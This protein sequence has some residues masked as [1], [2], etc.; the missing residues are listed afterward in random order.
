MV[1][2]WD[3][4]GRV[5]ILCAGVV[6]AASGSVAGGSVASGSVAGGSAPDA[7]TA[8]S[9]R[10]GLSPRLAEA[11]AGLS[12]EAVPT[13][14]LA[15]RVV[16]LVDFAG[17][18]GAPGE[19]P[20]TLAE[21]RQLYTQV[22]RSAHGERTLPAL[23]E[24][25]LRAAP[26]LDRGVVPVAVLDLPY[27]RIR[28]D[29]LETGALAIRAGRLA[30]GSGSPFETRR[31]FAATALRDRTYQ[32]EA[33]T[34][35][36]GRADYI[37]S[38]SRP[39]RDVAIDFADG[40][41]FVR[42]SWDHERTVR[43]HAP[44]IKTVRIRIGDSGGAPREAAFLFDVRRLRTP[45]PDD[46]L[47]IQATL[48]YLG[49]PGTG[50]AYVYLADEH[51]ALTNPVLVIEGFDLDN[52]MGWDELYELLNREEL[53]ETLRVRGFD[54]VVLDFTDAVDYIQRNAFVAVELISQ[55]RAAIEP[56]RTIAL[57]GASMGGLIGRFALAY[58]EA[59]GIEHGA[60]TFISFDAPQDGANVPLGLQYWLWFFAS[61]SPEAAALLAALDAPGARQMLCYHHTDPPGAT[62]QSDPLRAQLLGDLAALG[63]YPDLPRK[64]AI[65]NGSG[66]QA[67]Q[68]FQPGQQVVRWEYTSFLV[69][70]IGNI[71]AVPAGSTHVIFHGL[72][73]ILLLPEDEVIVAVTGT[74]PYDNAPG[75][76]RDS[77]AELDATAAPY[78]DIV[79]L[80][81]NHCFIP[82]T[83]AL[84]IDTEDLFYDIAGDPNLLS[85][86]PFDAVYF[87]L[88][89]EEHVAITPAN[90]QWFIA[91]VEHGA[92]GVTAGPVRPP[93]VASLAPPAPSLVAGSTL[94]RLSLPAAGRA[95]LIACD[96]TGREVAV[97]A[98]REFPA[99][100]SEVRWSVADRA[101][102]RLPAGA[103]FLSLRGA[104]FSATR[105]VIVP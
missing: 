54:A 31:L 44:G 71:W 64:V 99:G 87:P 68:G 10:R 49:V 73:D 19:R 105:R 100:E 53:L 51:T 6:A 11:L 103:Y 21:W 81:A 76:W 85:H 32:G 35:R 45:A 56:Q 78:G 15:D 104:G 33:V 27:E 2:R 66:T 80:Y 96:A 102:R 69:D 4:F 43:Y 39:P 67:G 52:S 23:R 72:I 24:L 13:G 34:F 50:D 93:I 40:R 17:H 62:G 16:Q 98:E 1:H 79:A 47:H 46:T 7:D 20:V 89:N 55:V 101:G 58:M 36:I 9:A 18:A 86:T 25:D 61:E 63:G 5:L 92:A 22:E 94:L 91:E 60:R 77:M 83:S 12:V 84:H 30:L 14:F 70:I 90:A 65:I 95:R 28:P 59:H 48:S 8:G 82:S 37:A 97:L 57:A 26:V 38:E 75:G 41:G 3:G 29:A 42:V 88:E 74:R